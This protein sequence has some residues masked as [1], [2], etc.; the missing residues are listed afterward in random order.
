MPVLWD[1]HTQQ[2][3]SNESAEIIR[4]L[5]DHAAA[6]RGATNAAAPAGLRLVPEALRDAILSA[7]SRGTITLV[8]THRPST[9]QAANKVLILRDGMQSRFG[10]KDEVMQVN[11]A[12]VLSTAAAAQSKPLVAAPAAAHV[13]G[14]PQ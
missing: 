2:I 9:L 3:V 7:Q 8:M 13:N 12:N 11:R 14:A 4:M 10:P 6:I 1:K 5:D